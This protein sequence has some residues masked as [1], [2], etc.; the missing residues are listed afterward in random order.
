[1]GRLASD[2][3]SLESDSLV[4]ERPSWS[5]QSAWRFPGQ[6]FSL[7]APARFLMSSQLLC[8]P[9]GRP[10]AESLRHLQATFVVLKL[11]KRPARGGLSSRVCANKDESFSIFFNLHNPRLLPSLR[12]NPLK[13]SSN[14]AARRP[15]SG[16]TFPSCRTDLLGSPSQTAPNS[17]TRT[18]VKTI[19]IVVVV[20]IRRRQE[21]KSGRAAGEQ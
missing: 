12:L 8:R 5:G 20:V 2:D 11:I 19:I 15:K 6:L 16:P 18:K 14:K 13:L 7:E 9:A 1:M 17:H 21:G 3:G 10:A 4:L